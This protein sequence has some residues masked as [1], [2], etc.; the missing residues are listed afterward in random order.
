[1]ALGDTSPNTRDG[2]LLVIDEAFLALKD[3]YLRPLKSRK[4]VSKQ[5]ELNTNELQGLTLPP[6]FSLHPMHQ[7][8]VQTPFF[9]FY[10]MYILKNLFA[11]SF[12]LPPCQG[13]EDWLRHKADCSINEC[14]VDVVQQ[15]NVART[16]SHKL[17]VSMASLAKRCT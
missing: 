13:Y 3:I 4:Q 11:V 2:E 5:T 12:S 15:G 6:P 17:R 9:F 10:Y 14:P 7:H 1:M 16:Q 8:L